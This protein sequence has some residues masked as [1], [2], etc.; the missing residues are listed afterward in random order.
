VKKRRRKVLNTQKQRP[1][2]TGKHPYSE[3][4]V[5]YIYYPFCCLDSCWVSWKCWHRFSEY[6]KEAIITHNTTKNTSCSCFE[7][8]VIE[9]SI[10]LEERDGG[11]WA[12]NVAVLWRTE[13]KRRG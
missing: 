10:M 13:V 2:A 8:P 4:F 9:Y 12:W 3:Y 6:I 5:K 1:D 11:F 7:D